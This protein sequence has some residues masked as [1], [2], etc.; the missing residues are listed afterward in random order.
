[1]QQIEFTGRVTDND[2]N[3]VYESV[4]GTIEIAQRGAL[5]EWSGVLEIESGEPPSL[6]RGKLVVG[7]RVADAFATRCDIQSDVILF[8]GS[9]PPP[10]DW[11]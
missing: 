10:V 9:G 6:F 7:D 3:T 2:G 1:M 11:P 8:Q 5:K 4:S